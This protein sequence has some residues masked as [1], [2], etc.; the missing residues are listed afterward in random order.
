MTH[1]S[2]EDRSAHS[3]QVIAIELRMIDSVACVSLCCGPPVEE[4]RRESDQGKKSAYSAEDQEKAPRGAFRAC[5]YA[6]LGFPRVA[7]M[8]RHFFDSAMRCK[9]YLAG[10]ELHFTLIEK[11][12]HHKPP[13]SPG[14]GLGPPTCRNAGRT[15]FAQRSRGRWADGLPRGPQPVSYTHLRAHETLR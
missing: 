5:A 9:V 2:L 1:V 6:L 12:S 10:C 15:G 11:T 8:W 13:Q 3:T 14:G 7:S 4:R